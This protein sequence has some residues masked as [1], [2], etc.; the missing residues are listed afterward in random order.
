M[1]PVHNPG[2][3][4]KRLSE[5]LRL[6]TSRIGCFV[7][8]EGGEGAPLRGY[9][10]ISDIS[11]GGFGIYMNESV[12]K[13]TIVKV[14]LESEAS[15]PYRGVVLWSRRFNLNQRFHS[16]ATLDYRVGVQLLFDSESERQR[17][18]MY[19]NELRKRATLL[20]GE[21]KF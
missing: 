11:D 9:G 12:A 10:F 2:R 7:W 8:V 21:F 20:S 16:Q 14:S 4:R 5:R 13:T 6:A 3:S 19:F 15:E 18:L 1:C 17:Y